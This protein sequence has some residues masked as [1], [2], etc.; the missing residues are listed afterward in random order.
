MPK[1]SC[2]PVQQDPPEIT[3][4]G[5]EREWMNEVSGRAAYKCLPLNIAN[6]TG[7]VLLNKMAF[8]VTWDG[9]DLAE[10]ISFS[11]VAQ[12]DDDQDSKA[13]LPLSNYVQSHFGF[14]VVT[15]MA[16]HLFKTSEETHMWAMGQPNAVKHG[17]Q[18]LAGVVE[19]D[20]L[21]FPFTMNWKFTAPGTVR[22]EK[23]EP[24]C[25]ITLANTGVIESIEPEIISLD[26]DPELRAEYNGWREKRSDFIQRID[27]KDPAALK[28]QWQKYYMTG[29][30]ATSGEKT[31]ATHYNK[32][33][34]KKPK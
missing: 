1:L 6:T 19:T 22:F 32:R 4:S 16:G 30:L 7:W 13:T 3:P 12:A 23:D 31:D 25:F 2:Y 5:L 27:N 29:R 20:W 10:N 21:P 26:D 8:D 34:L 15:F 17:I 28:E 11:L 9:G 24:F 14:G 33:K 18:P